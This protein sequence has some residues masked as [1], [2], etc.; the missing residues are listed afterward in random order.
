FKL[1]RVAKHLLEAPRANVT[2][3]S[4]R[5][6]IPA[7]TGYRIGDCLAELV[8]TGR[9][10][11][12]ERL[13]PAKAAGARWVGH[14][15]VIDLAHIVMIAAVALARAIPSQDRH[16]PRIKVSKIKRVRRVLYNR[17]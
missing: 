4:I 6:V 2:D 1:Y 8:R 5:V 15:G 13:Q 17:F 9:G 11:R 3:F 12:I 16:N 14:Y 7:R 10:Q